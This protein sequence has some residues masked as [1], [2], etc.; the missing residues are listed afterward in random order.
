MISF[1]VIYMD[2]LGPKQPLRFRVSRFRVDY[3]WKY[4]ILY[5]NITIL[6]QL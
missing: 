1:L 3:V 6:F 4:T 2:A 5:I